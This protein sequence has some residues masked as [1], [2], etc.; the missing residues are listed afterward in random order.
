MPGG[1]L[2]TEEAASVP[3]LPSVEAQPAMP[4][5]QPP[6]L[7]EVGADEYAEAERQARELME[8]AKQRQQTHVLEAAKEDVP[9]ATVAPTPNAPLEIAVPRD[10]VTTRVSSIL[11]E[12]MKDYYAQLDPAAQ[13][14]FKEKGDEVAGQIAVM[15][16]GFKVNVQKV[17]SLIRDWF[18]TI[19]SV[20]KF[21]IEQEAKIK[22]DGI[23]QY[24]EDFHNQ[25]TNKV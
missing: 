5:V 10:E 18:L 21:Y 13:V 19:P 14:R 15:V 2:E 9:V 7:K 8:Q 1:F 23:L 25:Q 3:S 24:E 22:T 4:P 16:R 12:G 20:N 6:S 17:L 11:E